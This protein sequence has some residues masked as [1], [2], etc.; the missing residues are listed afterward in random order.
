MGNARWRGARL[1][2]IL[3]RAGVRAGARQVVFA[4]LDHPVLDATP[5][6]EKA[7]DLDHALDGEVM[8]AYAMNGEDL[9]M[10]NGFPLRLV[11]PGYYGTYWVKHLNRITLID[12]PFDGYWMSQAYRIP[13]TP[14]AT[15]PPGT[16][17][18]STVPIGRL[19]VRSFITS[20]AD[21]A[22]L[23]VGREIAVRGIAFDGG[24][25][26]FQVLFSNDGGRRWREAELGR[27]FGRFSFREW[28]I[29]Y[30]PRQT[31]PVELMAKATN[32]RGETQPMQ[33]GWNPAGYMR[34]VVETVHASIA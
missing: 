7:L 32:R 23:R 3:N 14:D 1:K 17:P 26:I 31:G 10:L 4:G 19:N 28:T 9:P 27:G 13:T 25:G 30:I 20:V 22:T 33:A 6:F 29:P 12:T 16:A 5:T 8:V 2:D 34:N 11:V 18:K 15:I 21:N 24:S